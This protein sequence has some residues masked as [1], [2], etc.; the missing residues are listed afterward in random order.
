MTVPEKQKMSI[1]KA[2]SALIAEWIEA[3]DEKS[4]T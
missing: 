2:T 3:G 1:A 4:G